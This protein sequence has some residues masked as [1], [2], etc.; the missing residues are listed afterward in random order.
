MTP[1]Y[2]WSKKTGPRPNKALMKAAADLAVRGSKAHLAV[3]MA[4]RK[5]GLTQQ[6]V[7]RVLGQPCRNKLKQLIS[8][9]LIRAYPLPS[10]SRAQRLRYVR[11]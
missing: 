9:G 3:A 2:K 8:A 7:I 4:L 10:T 5:D 6:E 11:R 1:H